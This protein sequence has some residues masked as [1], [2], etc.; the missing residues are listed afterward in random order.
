MIKI[1]PDLI[2]KDDVSGYMFRWNVSYADE[3]PRFNH[4]LALYQKNKIK[5]FYGIPH[6][7]VSLTGE[8]VTLKNIELGHNRTRSSQKTRHNSY[9]WPKIHGEYLER[10]KFRRIPQ[11]LLPFGYLI[12][13]LLSTLASLLKGTIAARDFFGCFDYHLRLWHSFYLHRIGKKAGK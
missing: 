11:I 9:E 7:V 12:Y 10:Y 4:K 8:V 1:I 5:L 3:K 2:K 13:P 6:E